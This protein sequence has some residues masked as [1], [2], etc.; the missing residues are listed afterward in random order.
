MNQV[1]I[2]SKESKM[3]VRTKMADQNLIFW[4]NF[5]NIQ[6]FFDLLVAFI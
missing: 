6:H 4:H 1:L 2:L 3:M 5:E